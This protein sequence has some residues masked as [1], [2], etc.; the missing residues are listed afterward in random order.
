[1]GAFGDG[2]DDDDIE[3]M[4]AALE[5]QNRALK[6][7]MGALPPPNASGSRPPQQQQQQQPFGRQVPPPPTTSTTS[8]PP[9]RRDFQFDDPVAMAQLARGKPQPPL[10]SHT[11][12]PF[13]NATSTTDDAL[14][15]AKEGECAR[16]H[17]ER[18]QLEAELAKIP[19]D[20]APR[21]VAGR[22][23]K[24]RMEARLKILDED[25]NK[26]KSELRAMR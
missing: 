3:A 26:L 1:M 22:T 7:E 24:A 9:P 14:Y 17:L 23:H 6:G 11:V 18:Q 19:S 21:T 25:I 16:L 5:A 20:R 2:D 8:A 13:A 15:V 10:P 4:I 12:A